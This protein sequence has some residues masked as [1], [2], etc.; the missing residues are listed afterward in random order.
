MFFFPFHFLYT[1]NVFQMLLANCD[2]HA[3]T[4]WE[5]LGFFYTQNDCRAQKKGSRDTVPQVKKIVRSFLLTVYFRYLQHTHHPS[6]SQ[7]R[8]QWFFFL[9]LGQPPPP[10]LWHQHQL[11]R[12]QR[13]KEAKVG[14]MTQIYFFRI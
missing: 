12:P 3:N 8:G 11:E 7:T 9:H 4:K 10:R 5:W 1:N 6:R 14:F 2:L 13:V